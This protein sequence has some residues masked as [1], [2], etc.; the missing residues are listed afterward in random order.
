MS[1]VSKQLISNANVLTVNGSE[2]SVRQRQ[3]KNT[4]L[5][6]EDCHVLTLSQ[7]YATGVLKHPF[8]NVTSSG[9]FII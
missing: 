4:V 7:G 1:C 3:N 6:Q 2:S 9:A 5:S 8:E